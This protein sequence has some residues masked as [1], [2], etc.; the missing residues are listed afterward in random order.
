MARPRKPSSR[1]NR[2]RRNA[3]FSPDDEA[4][5]QVL[6]P[7]FHDNISLIIREGITALIERHA[8]IENEIADIV[9][10]L[11][12]KCASD[13]VADEEIMQLD[14]L[15]GSIVVARGITQGIRSLRARA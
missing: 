1:D 8:Q 5:L 10:R 13:E 4:R 15:V 7:E 11:A 3:L 12:E 9:V 14:V 6:L 2:R